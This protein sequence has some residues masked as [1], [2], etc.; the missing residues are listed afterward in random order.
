LQ[1]SNKTTTS[2]TRPDLGGHDGGAELVGENA[3]HPRVLGRVLAQQ[4]R[5]RMREGLT[6]RELCKAGLE[7]FAATRHAVLQQR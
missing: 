6:L 5:R 7:T 4:R 1:N 2:N 3:I